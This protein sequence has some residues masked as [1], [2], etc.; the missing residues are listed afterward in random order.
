ML[1]QQLH[2]CTFPLSN[3]PFEKDYLHFF[4]LPRLQ[5]GYSMII[6]LQTPV[7]LW[8]FMLSSHILELS[9]V[10]TRL[11]GAINDIFYPWLNSVIGSVLLQYFLFYF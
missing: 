6:S 3:I 1:C 11:Q 8:G 7:V 10:M 2:F 5:R 9:L 4:P